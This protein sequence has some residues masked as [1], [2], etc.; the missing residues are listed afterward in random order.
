MD[1]RL[2]M[3][4]LSRKTP[5]ERAAEHTALLARLSGLERARVERQAN[6]VPE[7]FRKLYLRAAV[8]LATR[9]EALKARCL[10]CSAWQRRE[11][12]LCT[13]RG[14]P[15]WTVR[16]WRETARETAEA[17]ARAL[18]AEGLFQSAAILRGLFVGPSESNPRPA[19]RGFSSEDDR[20]PGSVVPQGGQG[21]LGTS[22]P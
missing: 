11:V 14:C 6:A 3:A 18:E 17:E 8:G 16:P 5:I 1:D 20:Q 4:R 7:H 9:G 10:D 13:A 2:T 15:L 19:D 12:V 21:R 22:A